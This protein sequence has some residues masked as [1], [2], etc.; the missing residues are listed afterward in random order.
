M[1]A[2]RFESPPARWVYN[3][4]HVIVRERGLTRDTREQDKAFVGALAEVSEEAFMRYGGRI[5]E[6]ERK[7]LDAWRAY[8]GR[9]WW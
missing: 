5:P 7:T 9:R 4:A 6:S 3:L 1:L 8:A 2:T